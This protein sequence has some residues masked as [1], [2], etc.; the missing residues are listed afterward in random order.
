MLSHTMSD[1][2]IFQPAQWPQFKSAPD[3]TKP[4]PLA[5]DQTSVRYRPELLARVDAIAEAAGVT[6]TL[7]LNRMVEYALGQMARVTGE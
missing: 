6:R 7:V 2:S 1:E 5:G 3:F 4:W